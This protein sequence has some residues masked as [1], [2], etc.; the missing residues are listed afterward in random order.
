MNKYLN[1]IGIKSKIAFKNLGSVELKKRNKVLETYIK[2]LAQNKKKIIRENIKDVKSCKREELIDRLIIDEKKIENIRSSINQIVKFGDPLGKIVQK[3][4]RPSN[5][6]IKKV[7]VPIGIMGIIYESRPNVTCDVSSL[8]L[9][10]GNVAILR[11]GSE[12]LNSNKILANLFRS[13]LEKNNVDKNC[14]QFIDKKNRK[15]VD[16]LLSKMS[17]YIDVIVPRGGKNLVKKVKKLSSVNVIGHLEGNCHVYV[18]KDA[19]LQMSKKVVLNSKM[20]STSICGAAETLLIDNKCIKSHALPIIR[21]LILLGCE[22][23]VDKKN[24]KN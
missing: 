14:I 6:I 24:W 8:C 12:S 1:N 21:E 11:G 18:D 19:D 15:I 17:N 10:S 5:L 7:T 3:W 2:S 16:Y 22:V 4:K 23:V 9:K 13:S 20:R